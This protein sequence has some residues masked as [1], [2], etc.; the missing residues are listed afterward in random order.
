[1]VPTWDLVL[2][3]FLAA[4]IIYGFLLGKDKIMITILGTYVGLVIAN[5]WG[6]QA[7]NWISGQ[8]GVLNTGW[9][10]GSLSIFIVKTALFAIVLLII[11]LKGGWLTRA[12]GGGPFGM[13]MPLVYSVLNAGLIA[14]SILDFLPEETK[15]QVVEKSMIAAPLVTYYS[16]WLILP[17]F[18]IFVFGWFSREP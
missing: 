12:P 18:F 11:A 4:S 9:M 16:W 6:A 10:H 8:S 14:A 7:F 1:M 15:K 5:Q 13:I 3:V 2:L 17:V